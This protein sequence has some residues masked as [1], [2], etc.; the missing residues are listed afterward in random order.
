M[1]KGRKVPP[2]SRATAKAK[3]SKGKKP[4]P[5]PPAE[6]PKAPIERPKKSR[7]RTDPSRRKPRMSAGI[8]GVAGD[9]PSE[10][11]FTYFVVTRTNTRGAGRQPFAKLTPVK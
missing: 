10:R 6:A 2:A 7:P 5:K 9:R 4:T 3:N 8:S 1:A 11:K